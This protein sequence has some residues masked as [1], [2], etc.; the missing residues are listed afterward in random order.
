[1]GTSQFAVDFVE[2]LVRQGFNRMESRRFAVQYIRDV[3]SIEE[4]M[5]GVEA[6]QE[7]VKM[8]DYFHPAG[9]YY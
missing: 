3:P 1:M 5:T 6:A 7:W 4:D 9:D 2:E 8:T